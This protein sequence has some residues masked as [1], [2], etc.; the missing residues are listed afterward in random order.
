MTPN[1]LRSF[2]MGLLVAAT[3][4]GIVY[5]LEPSS[6]STSKELSEEEMQIQLEDKGF[7]VQ[8]Q[9]ELDKQLADAQAEAAQE[10]QK[11]SKEEKEEQSKEE[12]VYRTIINVSSGMTAVDVGEVLEKAKIVKSGFEFYKKVEGQGV[13]NK[14]RPGTFEVDSSMTEDEMIAVIFKG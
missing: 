3:A 2:A 7:V 5:L 9:D 8:T 4:T 11:E 12:P 13:E 10:A 1:T 14:L 6:T